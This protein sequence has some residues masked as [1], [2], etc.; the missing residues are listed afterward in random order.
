[1]LVGQLIPLSMPINQ[2]HATE[3][4]SLSIKLARCDFCAAFDSHLDIRRVVIEGHL[5][6][7]AFDIATPVM[8]EFG[9]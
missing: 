8:T 4:V 3:V 2:G 9:I 1:M 7:F 6:W 5:Q